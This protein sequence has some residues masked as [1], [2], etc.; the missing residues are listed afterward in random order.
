MQI[1]C[2]NQDQSYTNKCKKHVYQKHVVCSYGSKFVCVD[3]KFSKRF[4]TYLR[5]DAVHNF[6]NNMIE[7]GKKTF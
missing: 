1:L 5:K 2:K 6:I 4:N 7:E 3:D